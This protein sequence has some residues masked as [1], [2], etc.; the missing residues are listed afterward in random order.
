M[1]FLGNYGN[2]FYICRLIIKCQ[3]PLKYTPFSQQSTT[4]QQP[5]KVAV[6]YDNHNQTAFVHVNQPY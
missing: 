5:T 1:K 4:L 6:I 2:K 3:I